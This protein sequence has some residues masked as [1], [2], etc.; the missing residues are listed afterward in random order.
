M[1][2][3]RWFYY[4]NINSLIRK[5]SYSGSVIKNESNYGNLPPLDK[6][7]GC[8]NIY[9]LTFHVVFKIIRT[10]TIYIYTKQTYEN[11]IEQ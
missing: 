2:F 6:N 3:S 4:N 10:I 8:I 11:L 9:S 5:L 1:H 7:K